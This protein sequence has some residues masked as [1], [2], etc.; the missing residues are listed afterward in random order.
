M[1]KTTKVKKGAKRSNKRPDVEAGETPGP[2]ECVV[3]DD[4]VSRSIERMASEVNPTDAQSREGV[5][6]AGDGIMSINN[7]IQPGQVFDQ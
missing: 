2:G 4:M 7:D 6:V 3:S 5:E 1:Q